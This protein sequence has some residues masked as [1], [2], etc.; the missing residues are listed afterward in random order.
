MTVTTSQQ[1]SGDGDSGLYRNYLAAV[2]LYRSASVT[3]LD[4]LEKSLR[5]SETGWNCP[6]VI[7]RQVRWPDPSVNGALLTVLL[8]SVSGRY[9]SSAGEA[10]G[11]AYDEACRL[12]G[13]DGDELDVVGIERALFLLL[14]RTWSGLLSQRYRLTASQALLWAA[15][16]T[17]RRVRE[18]IPGRV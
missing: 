16:S 2:P 9:V 15:D 14:G 7:Q 10:C 4:A 3:L 6:A 17:S 18:P 5:P 13:S 1:P 11:R 12:R 8:V